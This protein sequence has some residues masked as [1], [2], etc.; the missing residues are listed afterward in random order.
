MPKLNKLTG[1]LLEHLKEYHAGQEKA[2]SSKTLEAAFSI[3][4]RIIRRCISS[5]RKEGVPIC[6]GST[7]YYYAKTQEEINET[8]E[9]LNRLITKVSNSKN[10]LLS[11]NVQNNPHISIE[12]ILSI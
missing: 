4:G 10:G 8:I 3:D 12:I 1:V 2:V 11:A 5:L 9:W 7:G 6:S